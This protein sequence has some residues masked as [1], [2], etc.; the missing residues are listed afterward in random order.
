MKRVGSALS[1]GHITPRRSACMGG[2]GE[3]ILIADSDTI[4][5]EVSYSTT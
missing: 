5:P 4:V 1:L 3:V 2:M